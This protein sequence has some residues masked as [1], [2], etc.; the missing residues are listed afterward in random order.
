M[1]AAKYVVP[2]VPA[3]AMPSAF[4][5]TW[6]K[7]A[8]S[9]AVEYKHAVDGNPGT[10][11]IPAPTRDTVPSPDLGDIAQ[12]GLSRSSDAPNMFFP[13]KYFEQSL[14]GNGTMGPVT[15]VRIYSDNLMP[16]PAVDPRGIPAR[17]SRPVNQR[18]RRGIGQP[19]ALPQWN[20]F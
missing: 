17:L 5:P 18:G 8:A 9:G 3:G 4:M 13:T 14:D 10:M 2:G 6:T 11:G 19:R 16:V 1:T 7:Y 20:S 12:M 15:P